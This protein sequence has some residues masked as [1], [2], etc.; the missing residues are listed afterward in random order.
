MAVTLFIELVNLCKT[1]ESTTKKNEKAKYIENFLR[2]LKEE[3]VQPSVFM[4]L[5]RYLK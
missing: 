3:E 4:I 5:D 2:Q 1:L